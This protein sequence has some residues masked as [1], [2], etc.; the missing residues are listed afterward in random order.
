[1]DFLCATEVYVA[2]TIFAHTT[3]DHSHV[4]YRWHKSNQHLC[5]IDVFAFN[6]TMGISTLSDVQPHRSLFSSSLFSC[7]FITLLHTYINCETHWHGH[8]L[9]S[10][11]R[12]IMWPPN[13]MAHTK[14][15]CTH[16][17]ARK[18]THKQVNYYVYWPAVYTFV[19]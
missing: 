7:I 4:H 9:L 16:K 12:F 18:H 11:T 17:R 5:S 15:Q 10:C 3:C 8:G 2:S 14:T 1:M 6:K 19:S 13:R